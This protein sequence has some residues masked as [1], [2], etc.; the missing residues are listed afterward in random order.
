MHKRLVEIKQLQE[1][2]AAAQAAVGS[3]AAAG[4]AAPGS[5]PA[6]SSQASPGLKNVSA[7]EPCY[8]EVSRLTATNASDGASASSSP[9]RP[10]KGS[11]RRA[12]QSTDPAQQA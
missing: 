5:D 12:Q 10:P 1:K 11:S 9:S 7:M 8:I 6:T 4:D 2:A 3:E